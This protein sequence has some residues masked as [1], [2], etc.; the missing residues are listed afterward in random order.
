MLNGKYDFN[1][2]ERSSQEPFFDALGTPPADKRRV[3]YPTGHNLP[4]NEMITE[5]LEWLDKY[6]GVVD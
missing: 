2:P 5:T 6:L 4:R 3:V 1:F